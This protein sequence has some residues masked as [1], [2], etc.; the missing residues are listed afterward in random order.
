MRSLFQLTDSCRDRVDH[1]LMLVPNR[2]SDL[3]I[4]IVIAESLQTELIQR[5]CKVRIIML[6]Y[7]SRCENLCVLIST[8]NLS[9]D[10]ESNLHSL[11]SNP[12]ESCTQIVY[13]LP[14]EYKFCTF[15]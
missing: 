14:F 10:L 2:E 5:H 12:Y 4:T 11:L 1:F 15:I 6:F 7:E 3:L 13:V 8:R 9:A